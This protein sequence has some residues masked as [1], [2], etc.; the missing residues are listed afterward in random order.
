M[1]KECS[2]LR[3]CEDA[4]CRY[5]AI[6]G[7]RVRIIWELTSRCN[8]H[9][10]HCFVNVSPCT[11]L[12]NDE[13]T[14]HEVSHIIDQ[15]DSIPVGKIMLT[16]GEIFVRDDIEFIIKRIREKCKDIV[17]DITTNALLLDKNKIYSLRDLEIDEFSVSLDGPR[18]VYQ[19]IRGAQVDYTKL[20]SN[21]RELIFVGINI[22][23][24]MVLHKLTASTIE[25]TIITAIELGMSSFTVANLEKLPH[26]KFY[27]NDLCISSDDIY[28]ARLFIDQLKIKYEKDIAIRTIG[29]IKCGGYKNCT[30]NKILSI[31]RRGKY[32]HCLNEYGEHDV[33]LD[34]RKSSL[35]EAYNY[36]MR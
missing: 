18:D 5:R 16:G 20:I 31:D 32:C 13:L 35:V 9:C 23:G 3:V 7:D 19:K 24:I 10:R 29:F 6:N 21:I 22:D 36:F 14:T 4:S 26:S 15:L 8:L 25:Q 30:N 27:Y 28:E 34:S 11:K 12:V 33:R 2:S 1:N 17:I